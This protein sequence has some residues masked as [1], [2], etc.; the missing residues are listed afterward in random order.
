MRC[1]PVICRLISSPARTAPLIVQRTQATEAALAKFTSEHA[2]A[3]PRLR[4]AVAGVR[5]AALAVIAIMLEK[6]IERRWRA[7]RSLSVAAEIAPGSGN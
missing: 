2:A 3:D 1:A 7:S 6:D 5:K 4:E